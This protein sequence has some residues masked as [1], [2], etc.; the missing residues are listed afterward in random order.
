MVFFLISSFK[1]KI[2]FEGQRQECQPNNS[3][4]QELQKKPSPKFTGEEDF[5]IRISSLVKR[6]FKT[7]NKKFKSRVFC[8]SSEQ[9][10]GISTEDLKYLTTVLS[11]VLPISEKNDG[12]FEGLEEN[13]SG[14]KIEKILFYAGYGM[15]LELEI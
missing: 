7:V 10:Q 5:N 15:E 12:Y 11:F 4:L 14:K 9:S 6:N 13:M 8:S 1:V 2:L 3:K